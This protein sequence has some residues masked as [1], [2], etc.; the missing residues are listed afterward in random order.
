MLDSWKPGTQYYD[1]SVVLYEGV[2]YKIIQPHRSQGDW[3][4]PATPALWGR[5]EGGGGHRRPHHET[6]GQWSEDCKSQP[7][8]PSYDQ[9]QQQQQ[10]E[11]CGGDR[12]PHHE[13]SGQWSEDRK[14]QPCTPSHEQPQQQQQQ[15]YQA[16]QG[17]FQPAREEGQKHW[18]DIDDRKKEELKIGGGVLAG[19]GALAAGVYAYNNHGKNQEEKK[20]HVWSQNNWLRDAEQRTKAFRSGNYPGPVAWVL[21]EGK[22]IPRDAIEGGF[23]RGAPLYICR[24]YHEGGLM[25]GKA[26]S[27]FKKG[28]VIGYKK[29]EIHLDRY[30]ILV[31]DS[32]AVRWVNFSGQFNVAALNGVR[33]VEG[34]REPGGALQYIAQAP[35]NGAVHPGKACEEFDCCLIP[36]DSTEK[37]VKASTHA[38]HVGR[39]LG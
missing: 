32:R 21:N 27:V 26:C 38:S 16:P 13:T 22:S 35:Y 17:G 33:L 37:K 2:Q 30:E 4:P 1:G 19:V 24:A 3:T 12:R 7:C 11:G 23:E 28:A 6:S 20:A 29:E 18:Y 34:G 10:V 39:I 14:S 5:M 9:P 36:Y 15:P 8:S 31:G 25:I